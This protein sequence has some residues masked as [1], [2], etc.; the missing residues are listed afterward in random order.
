MGPHPLQGEAP[1]PHDVGGPADGANP[2][3]PGSTGGAAGMTIRT[4][5]GKVE[6]SKHGLETDRTFKLGYDQRDKAGG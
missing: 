2:S 6:V 4:E 3:H 1:G 5:E